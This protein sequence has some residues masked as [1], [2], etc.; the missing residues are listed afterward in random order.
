MN[1]GAVLVLALWGLLPGCAADR[2]PPT[3]LAEW[4]RQLESYVWEQGNGD[5]AVL[6]DVSWDNV[7]PGF[8]VL[9]N[10]LPDH[11]TDVYGLLLAH[12][13]IEGR[14]HFVFLVALVHDQVFEQILP[15]ALNIDEGSFHWVD[16]P[17]DEDQLRRY[18]QWRSHEPH[19]IGVRFPA[20]DETF[21]V[22][23]D[24]NTVSI[25]QQPTGAT[26]EVKLPLETQ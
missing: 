17:A 21:D 4:R 13:R 22:R 5:P 16:G 10:P 3:T 14:A 24:G 15:V 18:N 12:P 20:E 6:A 11:S 1:R 8:A 7:H 2:A 26:W 23:I 9:A 19:V 25:T